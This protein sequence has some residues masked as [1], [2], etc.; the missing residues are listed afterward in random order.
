M[1]IKEYLSEK[2]GVTRNEIRDLI[3]KLQLP[4]VVLE[5]FDDNCSDEIMK[6]LFLDKDFVEP[7][8][9]L[10]LTKEQQEYYK[11]DRYKP[12]LAWEPG[13]IIAYDIN[14]NGFVVYSVELFR[15][16]NLERLTWEGLFVSEILFLWEMER[17]DED[18]LYMGNLFGLENVSEMLES[19]NAKGERTYDPS[20]E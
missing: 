4:P 16:E 12:L 2:Q 5:L 19:L 20:F 10:G 9:I 18:I 8:Y 7:Y 6:K 3:V 1:S 13:R 11:T 15:E 17:S 14:T